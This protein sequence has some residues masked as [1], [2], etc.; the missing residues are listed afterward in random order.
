MDAC[1]AAARA[2]ASCRSREVVREQD[3]SSLHSEL[4]GCRALCGCS[5]RCDG[6][7][8]RWHRIHGSKALGQAALQAARLAALHYIVARFESSS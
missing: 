8:K 2:L 6:Q 3:A 5:C 4:D 7:R 1:E